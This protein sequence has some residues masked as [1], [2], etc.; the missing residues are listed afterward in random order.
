MTSNSSCLHGQLGNRTGSHCPSIHSLA[1]S[2]AWVFFNYDRKFGS[3]P[4]LA[5]DASNAAA[6]E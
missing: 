1:I 3:V 5:F 6:A 4:S 2:V